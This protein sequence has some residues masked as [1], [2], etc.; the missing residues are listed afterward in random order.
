[1][2]KDMIDLTKIKNP[3]FK[4]TNIRESIIFAIDQIMPEAHQA[5]VDIKF[6]CKEDLLIEIDE[7]Q[8]NRVLI[9]LLK[10]SIYFLENDFKGE[11]KKINLSL[12]NIDDVVCLHILDNGP[13]INEYDIKKIFDYFFTTKGDRGM[14]FGLAISRN[15]INAHNGTITVKSEWGYNT[16]FI[17]KLP[18]TQKIKKYGGIY[19]SKQ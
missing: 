12:E 15:I 16:E 7:R 10:N 19:E 2:I 18:F 8:I 11:R 5:R 4:T 17:I 14:G 3:I 9:N 13:G 6:N 1:M